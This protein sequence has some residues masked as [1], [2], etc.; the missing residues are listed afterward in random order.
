MPSFTTLDGLNISYRV[1]GEGQ[2]VVL[3]H[4][5]MV[6][7]AIFNPLV[8]AL[9]G[10]GMQLI[11]PDQRGVADSAQPPLGYTLANYST[12]L[13]A[14]IE[15]AGL[16]RFKL[17][18]H[19]MGGQIAQRAAIDLGDRIATMVLLCTVPAAGMP[20]FPTELRGLFRT[21]A[22]NPEAQTK[23][24]RMA[25]K[26]LDDDGLRLILSTAA[27]VFPNCIADAFEAWTG[28]GFEDRLGE[29]RCSKTWVIGTDDPFLPPD[30]LK[31]AVVSQIPN[32]EFVHIPGIGHYPQVEAP[33]VTAAKLIELLR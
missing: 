19:S 9:T 3:V 29:I 28:G 23:I 1:Y 31:A 22:G 16:K 32:A 11:V 17:L 21:C 33:A 7:G 24:L 26:Q 25:C 14:L 13:I 6:G 12:D 10:A 27:T 30:Y 4:G 15:T 2:P 8:D 18:G 20:S 5:W